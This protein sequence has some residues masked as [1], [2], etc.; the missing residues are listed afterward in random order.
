LRNMA[1][2]AQKISGRF[3]VLSKEN[4]GTRIILDLP[5]EASHV[6]R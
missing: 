6:S 4:E 5:K 3:T 1:A 2:R